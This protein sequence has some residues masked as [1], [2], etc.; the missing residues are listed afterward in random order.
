[1][2]RL[3]QEDAERRKQATQFG[4]IET[5]IHGHADSARP[6]GAARAQAAKAVTGRR[7]DF[8]LEHV[9]AVERLAEDPA[10]PD[11]V[12]ATAVREL[13]AMDADGKVH[14]HF[15]TVRAAQ[16]SGLRDPSAELVPG[17]SLRQG[18]GS[19]LRHLHAVGPADDLEGAAKIALVRARAARNTPRSPSVPILRRPPAVIA[20]LSV[21]AF[22]MTVNETDYWWLH[23][24]PAEIGVAL[25]AAQWEQFDDWVTQAATFRDAVRTAVRHTD[26]TP[27]SAGG[28]A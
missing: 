13:A 28:G 16:N 25:T 12:R 15:L 6:Q 23:Y 20:R 4:V 18:T 21:R 17:A 27:V 3:Y 2:K 8:T 5:G 14:G 22:L 19:G 1:L 10:T 7:S 11:Q 24:D 9:L 26:R